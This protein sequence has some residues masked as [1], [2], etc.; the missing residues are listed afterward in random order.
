MAPKARHAPQ[1]EFH[2]RGGRGDDCTIHVY[3]HTHTYIY[4]YL[5]VGRC[6]D[7]SSNLLSV[8]HNFVIDVESVLGRDE[9]LVSQL[10]YIRDPTGRGKMRDGDDVF[11]A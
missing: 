8:F 10:A 6:W 3:T 7:F 1:N 2:E 4:I 9:K 5:Q 11:D